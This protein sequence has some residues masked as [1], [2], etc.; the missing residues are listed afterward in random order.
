MNL[1]LPACLLV[2]GASAGDDRLQQRIES[3]TPHPR[4]LWTAAEEATVRAKIRNDSRCAAIWSAVRQAA[5]AMLKE[6]PVRYQK[7]GH[8]LLHRSREALGRITHLGFVAR[9]TGDPRY[10]ARAV[11]EMKAA[12]AMPDWNPSHYLDTAE[13][14]LAL[15]IGYD[16]LHAKLSPAER[17]EMREAIEQKGLAPYLK[18]GVKY[19]WQHY[20]N[21]WNQ[22]C[23]GGLVAGALALAG[24]D[25]RR[26]AEVI[27]RALNALPHAMKVYDPD[28]AYPEGPGY[29]TYGTTYSILLVAALESA[30][31]TDFG[32]TQS[33]GFLKTGDFLLH[34]TGVTG[35]YYNFSDWDTNTFFSPAMVWLA[36][37]TRRADWLW[38]EEE[39]LQRELRRPQPDRFFPLAILWLDPKLQ[40]A[41]PARR[42]W[43]GR[44]LNPLAA[45]RAAWTD[46]NALYLAIKAGSPG[47]S[48]GHMDIG[49][50]VLEADGVRWSLDL[51]AESY[52]RLE[53][54]RFNLWD[55]RQGADR[56]K[57]FRYH[58]RGHSTLV[59]D[60]Q[61]QIVHSHAP[62]TEFSENPMTATVDMTA[63]YAGQLASAK[64]RFRI[65]ADQRVV[66]EDHLKAG[67]KSVQVR[68]AIIT[69][70]TLQP[71]GWLEKDG[72]RLR[73]EVISP[74][75][76]KLQSWPADPPPN[77]F[78]EPNPGV[79]VVGFV[80]PL[81]AGE[82]TTWKVA[83]SRQKH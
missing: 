71:G 56:W 1:L 11:A 39:H 12:A 78:D 54:R 55:T 15:A 44:G 83:I 81:A 61:E 47:A 9:I 51:G 49:S 36:T 13:M 59:V 18:P 58:N 25:P 48:H 7:E 40:R 6:P 30:L 26:S 17:A 8:R 21:N 67:R 34:M 50:F 79:S 29:W 72:K 53:N 37:R 10:V 77:D 52:Y 66:I 82:E 74:A 42:C 2:A 4:L 14:T 46:P 64:R 75:N 73:L 3:A 45:F 27:C 60:D 35:R 20:S 70:A 38:F 31:G 63:T 65:E 24:D 68:W 16:W 80:A 69:A 5:D 33:P 41:E 23:H 43:F 76:S 28:G 57:L 22:V 32:L 19:W 62:I